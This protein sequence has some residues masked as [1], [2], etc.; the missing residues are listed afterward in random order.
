MKTTKRILSIVCVAMIAIAALTL[1]GCGKKN[2]GSIVGSWESTGTYGSSYVYKFNEDKTG[3]YSVYGI[4]MP[5]T[6]ED[7]GSKVTILYDGNTISNSFEYRI[8][9]N[10]LIIKDSFGSDVEYKRK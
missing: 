10:K 4:D 2:D 6:Y 5:F 1:T 7:D 3:A 9:G 8:E